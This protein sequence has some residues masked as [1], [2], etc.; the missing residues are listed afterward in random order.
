MR[1]S[2]TARLDLAVDDPALIVFM[3][4]VAHG[5]YS[6]TERLSV[7][8]DGQPLDVTELAGP[9]GTRLHQVAAHQ[10]HVRLDYR[11]SVEGID[12]LQPVDDIDLVTYLRPSRYA[13]SDAMVGLAAAELGRYTGFGLLAAVGRWV[14]SHL[15][16]VPG[17]SGP[18]DGAS[19]TVLAGQ[20]VCR[21][22]AHVTVALLRALDVPA[23]LT[24]VYAPGLSPM[25]FHA[26]AEA[27]VDG[28][29]WV[30]DAT[31]LAP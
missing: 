7:T 5:R 30:V 17:S 3:I 26:V 6:L 31:H 18:N 12:A 1:R 28:A 15:A 20:G 16:Y 23:R 13:E 19:R 2:V 27:Y 4:A 22:Y 9:H 14:A 24:A 8:L 21:D 11:A 10:G 25:D 29:W